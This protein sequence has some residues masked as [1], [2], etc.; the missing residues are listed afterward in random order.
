[1]ILTDEEEGEEM[2][3][4]EGDVKSTINERCRFW[5]SCA[6]GNDC[7]FVHPSIPCK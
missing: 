1:M 3:T 4:D 6:N 2:D 5:P 7:Q